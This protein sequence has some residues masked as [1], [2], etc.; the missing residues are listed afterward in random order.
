MAY[1]L[2]DK[3]SQ[4]GLLL[5]VEIAFHGLCNSH[6]SDLSLCMAAIRC[7]YV[8][9]HRTVPLVVR[10]NLLGG[11]IWLFQTERAPIRAGCSK[12]K[13]HLATVWPDPSI[14][15]LVYCKTSIIQGYQA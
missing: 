5:T 6:T 3:M 14:S 12:S 9:E 13:R 2:L 4:V 11:N 7:S 8:D 15:F 10:T 1:L